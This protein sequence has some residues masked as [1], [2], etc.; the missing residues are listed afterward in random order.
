MC[1][2]VV[3]LFLATSALASD[4]PFFPRGTA[5][6]QSI[7]GI[8]QNFLDQTTQQRNR[9]TTTL[10]PSSCPAGQVLTGA[11][12]NNGYTYGGTC[13]TAGG[14]AGNSVAAFSTF[15]VSTQAYVYG[16]WHLLGS[17]V[18]LGGTTSITFTGLYSTGTFWLNCAI[19]CGSSSSFVQLRLNSDS[20]SNYTWQ[21]SGGQRGTAQVTFSDSDTSC[22]WG[23]NNATIANCPANGYAKKD[24]WFDVP[25]NASQR[26]VGNTK[27]FA[28]DASGGPNEASSGGGCL[29]KG[30]ASVTSVTVLASVAFAGKCTL[31]EGRI[32]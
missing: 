25:I 22:S 12:Y 13:A 32:P 30:T 8:N 26:A 15:T 17:S 11:Y 5:T 20:G 29:Y 21:D 18:T 27:S 2:V 1:R 9:L 7:G 14:G 10:T 19:A 6:N 24:Y 23:T 4:P 28:S 16:L 3:L 31:W